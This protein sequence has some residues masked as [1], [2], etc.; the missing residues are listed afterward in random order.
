MT[1]TVSV[2]CADRFLAWADRTPDRPAVVD[3]D[4]TITYAALAAAAQDVADRLAAEDIRPGTLVGMSVPRGWHMIAAMLGTWLHGCGYVP[5]DPSYPATRRD[6]ISADATVSHLITAGLRIEATGHDGRRDDVPHDTAYVIYTSGTTGNPKGVVVRHRNLLAL[7]D[8]A[9]EVMP[10]LPDDVSS[11]FH[12]A[13]FDLSVW[14]MW[15]PLLS[16]GSCVVVPVAATHDANALADLFAAHGVTRATIVPSI[17]ANFVTE[18]AERPVAMPRL[19]EVVFCGEPIGREAIGTWYD[20]DVAPNAQLVNMYGPTETTV[21]VSWKN[22]DR[23]LVADRG[24]PGTPIGIPLPHLRVRVLDEHRRP[25][26]EGEV[27]IAGAGVSAGYLGKP[28]LTADRFV[29]LDDGDVWYRSGDHAVLGTDGELRFLGRK[30]DQVKVRGFRIE[31]GEVDAAL[32]G[33]PE[34]ASA[35]TVVQTT[36]AGESILV[37]GYVPA[38]P[39]DAAADDETVRARLREVL[40][41]HMI[42]TRLVRVTTLPLSLSGK[43]NRRTLAQRLETMR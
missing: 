42:P 24:E 8:A 19:R 31:L 6:Y 3:G 30:D 4:T 23:A 34:I 16:G 40:P 9:A 20:L 2:S 21:Y 28:E 36:S 41:Q 13:N 37:A 25:A 39:D 10:C 14:E 7:L 12:S 22:L 5:I 26:R 32:R 33:L 15:R 17:F 43:L 29:V 35:G 27:Y 11:V 18:L 38:G 1:S